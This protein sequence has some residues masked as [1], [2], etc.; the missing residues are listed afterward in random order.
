MTPEELRGLAVDVVDG[1][2]F[3]SDQVET[4]MLR[5]VFMA[6]HFMNQETIDKWENE[7][8]N[9]PA[10]LYEY[11]SEAGP[12]AINGYPVFTSFRILL[13]ADTALFRKYVQEYLAMRKQFVQKKADDGT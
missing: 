7:P 10:L 6:V 8:E 1:R 5:S 12:M 13:A 11:I 2:V 9:A 4:E 3:T